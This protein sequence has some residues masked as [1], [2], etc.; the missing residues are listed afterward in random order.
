[1][2]PLLC[3]A[4]ALLFSLQANA[5]LLKRDDKILAQ[6]LSST[7]IDGSA[8]GTKRRSAR[9]R[10]RHNRKSSKSMHKAVTP[11]TN[12]ND[13]VPDSPNRMEIDPGDIRPEDRPRDP[14]VDDR[15]KI[16]G[17]ISPDDTR[18]RPQPKNK[19]P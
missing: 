8:Q 11:K 1:M 12:G 2:R 18:P 3:V 16:P 7:V 10:A 4:V 15:T 9:R 5:A 19:K 6:A 17:D 13:A 14:N